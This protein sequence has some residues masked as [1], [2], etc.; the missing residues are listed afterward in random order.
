MSLLVM[1]FGGTSV[2]NP[3]CI[4]K[5]ACLVA[6]EVNKGNHVAVVVSAMAGVTDSLIALGKEITETPS[7][8]EMDVL[9]ATGE[10]RTSSLMAMTLCSMGLNARS[11]QGWQMPFTTSAVHGDA[12]ILDVQAPREEMLQENLIPV[13]AGFQGVTKDGCIT[14]LGRGGSD[15]SAVALAK[16]LAADRCDIYTDVDGVYTADPRQVDNVQKI[17]NISYEEMLELASLGSKVLQ[18]R[19]V[20]MGC[21]L[22]DDQ[23]R[24]IKKGM[25]IQVLSSLDGVIGSDLPGTLVVETNG[26]RPK[27]PVT[28][29]AHFEEDA[30]ITL[31]GVPDVSGKAA[32]IFGAIAKGNIVVD[33]IAQSPANGSKTTAVTFTLPKSRLREAMDLLEKRKEAIG[34]SDIHANDEVARISLVGRGMREKAGVAAKAFETLGDLGINIQALHTSEISLGLIVAR[35]EMKKSLRALHTAFGLDRA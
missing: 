26:N 31:E 4:K 34:F 22:R 20:E 5:A 28:G 7:K 24:M 30:R 23:G 17:K 2:A 3:E 29:I 1:K 14:T 18:V 33:M 19:S 9:L 8:R 25:P 6:K 12:R 35:P 27:D 21:P 13:L 32:Q 16:A 15:T 11:Y 10:Q